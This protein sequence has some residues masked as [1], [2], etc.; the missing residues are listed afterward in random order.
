ATNSSYGAVGFVSTATNAT[1]TGSALNLSGP[2][3]KASYTGTNV[4]YTALLTGASG[5]LV[6]VSILNDTVA[7]R[8]NV[9]ITNGSLTEVYAYYDLN[10]SGWYNIT[11]WQ[12]VV[13]A[14]SGTK[15]TTAST[16]ISASLTS[17]GSVSPENRSLSGGFDANSYL[18]AG[19]VTLNTILISW[20]ANT[21]ATTANDAASEIIGLVNVNTTD[22]NLTATGDGTG[23]TLTNIYQSYDDGIVIVSADSQTG[24]SDGTT[25]NGGSADSYLSAGDLVINGINMTWATNYSMTNVAD[26]ATFFINLINT[27]TTEHNISASGTSAGLTLTQTYPGVQFAINVTEEN[28]QP[29]ITLG[30][31]A[32]GQ[33]PYLAAGYVV[34][35]GVNST[36]ADGTSTL[37]TTAAATTII[38]AINANSTATNVFAGGDQTGIDLET[39]I[40]GSAYIINVTYADA[41]SGISTGLN[42]SGRQA[43]SY[44]GAGSFTLNGLVFSWSRNISLT[45][46]AA[47]AS[48]FQAL[49]N[50]NTSQTNVTAL[51]APDGINLTQ[52]QNGSQYVIDVTEADDQANLTVMTTSNGQAAYLMGGSVILNGVNV[53]WSDATSNVSAADAAVTIIAAINVNRTDSNVTASGD[54]TGIALTNIYQSISDVIAVTSPDT[55]SGLST[56]TATNGR[57]ANSYLGPGNFVLNGIN[58]SWA[59]NTS[60]TVSQDEAT[61]FQSILNANT[62]KTNVTAVAG[63]GGINLTQTNTGSQYLINVSDGDPQAGLQPSVTA[64]GQAAYLA[65]GTVTVDAVMSSWADNTSTLTLPVAAQQIINAINLNTSQTNVSASGDETGIILT[66]TKQSRTQI[67]NVTAPDSQSGLSATADTSGRAP[68]SYLGAG[69][70]TLNGVTFAWSANTSM[71]S[72]TE[73]YTFFAS[74]LNANTSKTNVTASGSAAGLTLTQIYSASSR[75]IAITEADDQANLTV[76]TTSNGQAAYLAAGDVVINAVNV[77]WAAATGTTTTSAAASTIIA[78]INV[79]TSDHNVIASGDGTGITLT[80]TAPSAA[81]TINVS[82]GESQSNITTGYTANGQ[83]AYLAKGHVIITDINVSWSADQNNLTSNAAAGTIIAAINLNTSQH[84]VV[85]SGNGSGIT[86]TQTVPGN[87]INISFASGFTGLSAGYTDNGV[88]RNNILYFTIDSGGYQ[89]ITLTGG[90]LSAENVSLQINGSIGNATAFN[91]SGNVVIRSSSNGSASKVQMSSIANN[92][93]TVLGFDMAEHNGSAT[94]PTFVVFN[95][96]VNGQAVAVTFAPSDTALDVVNVSAQIN[97]QYPNLASNSS[98][99]LKLTSN[100]TGTGS[101]IV[102]GTGT[103][104]AVL[105]FTDGQSDSGTNLTY[106]QFGVTPTT[107]ASGSYLYA[108]ANWTDDSSIDHVWFVKNTSSTPLNI[109]YVGAGTNYWANLSYL[110][111]EAEVGTIYIQM[112]AN[113]TAGNQNVSTAIAVTV[114]DGTAPTVSL[115]NPVN[116]TVINDSF[117]TLGWT[118]TESSPATSFCVYNITAGGS[119]VVSGTKASSA[120]SALSGVTYTF[121]QALTGMNTSKY[122]MTVTC[123]DTGSRSTAPAVAFT[124]NDTTAPVVT[125]TTS[126]SGTSTKTVTVTAT[127]NEPATCKYDD[128]DMAYGSLTST[129]EGSGTTSHTFSNSYTSTTTATY[130]I[131]CRD[132]NGNADASSSTATYTATISSGSSGGGGG[133]GGTSTKGISEAYGWSDVSGGTSLRMF[134]DN[135]NIPVSEVHFKVKRDIGQIDFTVTELPVQPVAVGKPSL[136]VQSY[137]QFEMDGAGDNDIDGATITFRVPVSWLDENGHAAEDIVLLRWHGG[138]WQELVTKVTKVEAAYVYF[139][140]SSPGFSYFAI[141]AK[142]TSS[143]TPPA[144]QTTPPGEE[145]PPGEPAQPPAGTGEVTAPPKPKPAATPEQGGST[146]P[147]LLTL[148][149]VI[150]VGALVYFLKVGKKDAP[151]PLQDAH[152]GP[153]GKDGA[154][155]HHDEEMA[156]LDM[157]IRSSLEMGRSKAEIREILLDAGWQK[158]IINEALKHH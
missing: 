47:E 123:T 42:T 6:N 143:T 2:E 158:Q 20:G 117:F 121:S 86:L 3:I 127:T 28:A 64:N 33:A 62:S 98:G 65:A 59:A 56:T 9:S 122:N 58:F 85:A 15:N 114:T 94:I 157:Y 149:I 71:S 19:N 60:M 23:I 78:A 146:W 150:I 119:T 118:A 88:A 112:Y 81:L 96:T 82:D 142:G 152:E 89:T 61:F 131:R 48:F 77:S 106:D 120:Y 26:A 107:V 45:T 10:S 52:T 133:S 147:W 97:D 93:Y 17:D 25:Q 53:S 137:L 70:F 138:V 91:V 7:G 156:R 72:T 57:A 124:L 67:V 51:A 27:N 76:G 102:I 35:N 1:V 103:A 128:T 80:R 68:N 95:L 14:I 11:T 126:E 99:S 83:A 4:T 104:N 125:V 145:T 129:M 41:Q 16:L 75:T 151:P 12:H 154:H 39:N 111:T 79:N 136:K 148:F 140:A 109:T 116:S 43:D 8:L 144:E 134:I 18:A 132:N 63:L 44:L 155:I 32:N 92:A 90:N 36:W 73:A 66:S 110:L 105:G 30:Y 21:S 55:Q 108:Y 50:A 34:I 46:P 74:I 38:S 153:S 24:L 139:E 37:T 13:Y 113:D 29:N 130:Y 101:T 40:S 84:G 69:D 31:T 54:E 100:T 49:I 87:A 5:N 135:V 141:A 115:S 22:H